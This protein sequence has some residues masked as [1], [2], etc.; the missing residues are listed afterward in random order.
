MATDTVWVCKF[1][2]TIQCDPD[3]KEIT[4]EEMR[5]QLATI[6]GEKNIRAMEKRSRPMPELCGLPTGNTNA[7]EITEE[8]AFILEHG[9]VGPM[10]F[11]RCP[12]QGAQGLD[13][14]KPNIAQ[15]IGT[16]TSGNPTTIK[17]LV[18]HPLRAYK[19]GDPLTDDWRPERVN[20]E[21]DDGGVIVQVWFG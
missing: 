16:L 20:I 11:T 4:L 8:G 21:T 7:Y 9:F 3:S 2:G 6:I 19:T 10:G 5:K 1:D 15:I 14:Q 18:G 17:E 13:A 12:A